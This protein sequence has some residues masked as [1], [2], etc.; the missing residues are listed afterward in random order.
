MLT[1]SVPWTKDQAKRAGTLFRFRRGLLGNVSQEI[2][3]VSMGFTIGYEDGATSVDV[4]P[5]RVTLKYATKTEI[6]KLFPHGTSTEVWYWGRI[7]DL[8]RGGSTWEGENEGGYVPANYF[9]KDKKQ[10]SDLAGEA[11]SALPAIQLPADPALIR[12]MANQLNDVAAWIEHTENKK[13][14]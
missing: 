14:R 8:G 7:K 1:W 12:E 3:H 10:E 9:F 5:R 13:S 4:T 2:M 6:D 11:W